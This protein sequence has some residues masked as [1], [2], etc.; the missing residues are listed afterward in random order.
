METLSIAV[1]LCPPGDS[2]RAGLCK[3]FSF[4]RNVFVFLGNC[5]RRPAAETQQRLQ[6]AGQDKAQRVRE[7]RA[8]AP[9]ETADRG[10]T[11]W[12]T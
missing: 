5:C 10:A 6:E 2:G 4:W 11:D 3:L 8:A 9:A 1:G 12:P 7:L